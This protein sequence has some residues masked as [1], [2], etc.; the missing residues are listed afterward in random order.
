MTSKRL[1]YSTKIFGNNSR[2]SNYDY[3]LNNFVDFG[4]VTAFLKWI[5]WAVGEIWLVV[6]GMKWAVGVMEW[7]VGEIWLVVGGFWLV[8]GGIWLVVGGFWLVVSGIEGVGS[9]I[10]CVVRR[11]G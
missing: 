2:M 4:R 11:T 9:G 7:V 1:C 10:W 3:F 5:E 6:G 8:V